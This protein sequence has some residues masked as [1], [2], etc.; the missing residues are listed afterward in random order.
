MPADPAQAQQNPARV[1]AAV[2]ARDIKLPA[3]SCG[4]QF[5][6]GLLAL[7]EEAYRPRSDKPRCQRQ[8]PVERGAAAGGHDI[9]RVR[10]QRIDSRV[11]DLYG[12]AG[13]PRRLAQKGAFARIGFDQLDPG[14]SEDR[15]HQPRKPGAAAE[16]DEA[17]RARRDKRQQLRR[18]EEMAPPRIGEGAGSDQVDAR[19]PLGQQPGIGFE[20]RQCFT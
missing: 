17:L 16:I 10:R 20:P 9:D 8:K 7:W 2:M 1:G 11:A 19:R 3:L 4:G 18:I 13:A 12:R 6:P 15:Q 5:L 14:D